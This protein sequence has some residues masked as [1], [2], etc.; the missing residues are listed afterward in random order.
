VLLYGHD[1]TK[2]YSIN[3]Y[4]NRIR[5]SAQ[6][7]PG[8][9]FDG[10]RI[11]DILNYEDY[12]SGNGPGVSLRSRLDVIISVQTD[13]VL[14]HFHNQDVMQPDTDAGY[15]I[16]GRGPLLSRQVKRLSEYGS[17]HQFSVQIGMNGIYGVDL[18][19]RI[20]WVVKLETGNTGR[21][22]T[23]CVNLTQNKFIIAWLDG[24]V[25][26]ISEVSDI[27]NLLPDNP[28]LGS[29]VITGVDYGNKEIRFTF[30]DETNDIQRTMIYSELFEI[31]L[32]EAQY[33]P[34]VYMKINND[35]FT[36]LDGNKVYLHDRYP[37]NRHYDQDDYEASIS[38]VI[39][40]NT[41]QEN[42]R[43]LEKI[44]TFIHAK[45]QETAFSKIIVETDTQLFEKTPFENAARFWD[46]PEYLEGKWRFPVP[47]DLEDMNMQGQW[48]KVTLYFNDLTEQMYIREILSNFII[49]H[50]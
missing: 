35:F 33:N 3:N 20:I 11:F 42:T 45:T 23:T 16:L 50:I 10:Y 5:A 27:T 17:Y 31:F 43:Q 9:F 40:G 26:S 38:F 2:P 6:H 22:Y 18:R 28:I 44:F 46:N 48:M 39:N 12:D 21:R 15:L 36:S 13:A 25:D 8:S 30:L 14:Q 49:S 34:L 24:I 37:G 29:G 4:P 19:R 7:I 32:G 47:A 41:E 1:F